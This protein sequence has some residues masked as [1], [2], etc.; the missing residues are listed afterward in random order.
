[1]IIGGIAGFLLFYFTEEKEMDL[2]T[3]GDI[4]KSVLVGAF[5][6]FFITNKRFFV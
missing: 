1:M 4:L 6:W 3:S 5:F 2:I